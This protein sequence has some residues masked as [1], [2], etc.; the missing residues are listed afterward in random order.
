MNSL[1]QTLAGRRR[2]ATVVLA[3]A[4][5]L[6]GAAA[7]T[8][9]YGED[10]GRGGAQKTA[11]ATAGTGGEDHGDHD[12]AGDAGDAALLKS[13]KVDIKQAVDTATKSVPGTATSADLDD[14][15][16]KAVWEV[17]VTDTKGT[18]HE[19]TVD[20][21]TGKVTE[22]GP[23]DSHE[24]HDSHDSHDGHDDRGGDRGED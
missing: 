19:V 13:A 2:T 16:G 24:G 4:V 6:G 21:T 20:A 11:G 7:T 3:A 17:E 10:H 9:A 22:A 15:H 5:V 12:D 23:D 1:K 14:E 8:A 18:E